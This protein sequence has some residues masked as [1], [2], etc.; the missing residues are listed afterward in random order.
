VSASIPPFAVAMP[1]DPTPRGSAA[2]RYRPH[3]IDA[4]KRRVSRWVRP[5]SGVSQTPVPEPLTPAQQERRR[6]LAMS[7]TELA[8]EFGT[9]KWGLHFYTQH[10]DR[11]FRHLRGERFTLLEIG[12]GG[13]YKRREGGESLLMWKWFF[14]KARIIGLD[15]TDKSFLDRGRVR[16]F[17]GSQTD[18]EVLSRIV[19]E[20]GAPLVV[21]DDGS[22][23]PADVVAT[24][25]ALFPML[26]DG[27]LYAIEDIQTSYWPEWGGRVERDATD[28]SMAL[29]KRLVDG[30]N[31]EEYVDEDY[32][33]TYSD[34]HVVAV[35]CYHNLVIIE[36]GVNEEGTNKREAL[37]ERYG[38]G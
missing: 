20:E 3:V 9:D 36:K 26:P 22:H 38:T 7:L 12:V 19:E 37:P 23:K 10:Y 8:Q 35:H 24:F 15:I 13:Y 29:V 6:K 30:L 18:T 27:A 1:A 28:T 33:P 11:H 5:G 2:T 17:K 25:Q 21:I 34:K 16:T 31:Y 4:L 14:P 32:Q